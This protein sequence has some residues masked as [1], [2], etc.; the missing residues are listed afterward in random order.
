MAKWV[1]KSQ[2]GWVAIYWETVRAAWKLA[3]HDINICS[4]VLHC[5]TSKSNLNSVS[6][7]LVTWH[8]WIIFPNRIVSPNS[9]PYQI[10]KVSCFMLFFSRLNSRFE[11]SNGNVSYQCR[12][13]Q[14]ESYKMNL[15]ANRIVVTSYGTKTVPDPCQTIFQ[16]VSSTF[17]E[18]PMNDNS[19]ISIYPF[20]DEFFVFTECPIIHR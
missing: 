11:I 6:N 3:I 17:A 5:F 18:D 1:E 15:A 13:I 16:R 14:S 7:I 9:S 8:Y 20:G 4:T 12:F 19:N 2:N 10:S